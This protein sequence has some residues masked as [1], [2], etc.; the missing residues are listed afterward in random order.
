MMDT[1]SGDTREKLFGVSVAKLA[2]ALF[3]R[4]LRVQGVHPV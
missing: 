2:I 1:L 3:K 4:G